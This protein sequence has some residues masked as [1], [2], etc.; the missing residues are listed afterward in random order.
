[1]ADSASPSASRWYAIDRGS[2][3][4]VGIAHIASDRRFVAPLDGNPAV[5]PRQRTILNS[6]MA[7]PSPGWQRIGRFE[8]MVADSHHLSPMRSRILGVLLGSANHSCS[9]GNATLRPMWTN[10]TMYRAYQTVQ[11]TRL[12]DDRIPCRGRDTAESDLEWRNAKG[13]AEALHSLRIAH[14]SEKLPCSGVLREVVRDLVE[15]FGGAMGIPDISTSIEPMELASF[16]RRALVLMAGHL[17]IQLLFCAFR[18]RCSGQIRVTLDRPNHRLGRL[19][20]GYAHRI[21]PFGPSGGDHG[22]IDDLASLLE[23]DVSYRAVG[24]SIGVGVEFPLC[25]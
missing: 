20:V 7:P 6:E 25:L 4:A 17:V 13:L 9:G 1:M 22:V 10:E 2:L 11:L 23:S 14:D 5:R 24:G 15:L 3:A 12:L 21:T 8:Q 16:K 18:E 19:V